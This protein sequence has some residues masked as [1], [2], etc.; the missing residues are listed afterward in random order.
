MQNN[1]IPENLKRACPSNG[2]QAQDKLFSQSK[3]MMT[4]VK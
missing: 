3:V 4:G 2:I 1:N